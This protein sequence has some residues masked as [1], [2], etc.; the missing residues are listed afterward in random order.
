[1]SFLLLILCDFLNCCNHGEKSNK[2]FEFLP[3]LKNLFMLNI[4]LGAVGA[5]AVIIASRSGSGS[6]NVMRLLAA[7]EPQHC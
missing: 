1:M 6:S 7:S 2:M 3:L 5:A 4:R